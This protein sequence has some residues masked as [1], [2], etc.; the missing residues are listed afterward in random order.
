MKTKKFQ[1]ITQGT[2]WKQLLR[3]FI[4]VLFGSLFQMLYN[5]ADAIVVGRFVGTEALAAVGGTTGTLIDLVTGLFIGVASGASV[6]ISQYFGSKNIDDA[7]DAVHTAVAFS[8]S[9]GIV[10][11]IVGIWIAPLALRLLNTPESVMPLS[12]SYMRIYFSGVCF[13][14]FYNIGSSIQRSAGDSRR[15]MAVLIFCCILNISLD[16]LFVA[17]LSF[18]V[19]GAAWATVISQ[20]I[21]SVIVFIM[22]SQNP[23][24]CKV[25]I[26]KIK[27]HTIMLKEIIR[28]GLPVG[29][30]NS[31]YS[32]T[33]VFVQS[34]INIFGAETMA[35]WSAV[36]R[37][38]AMFWM[39]CGAIGVTVTTFS[40][41]NYG[42]GRIDRIRNSV[43]ISSLAGFICAGVF[44]SVLLLEGEPVLLM[45]STDSNVIEIGLLMFRCMGPFYGAYI[46]AETISAAMHGTGNTFI[47]MCISIASV[48]L[49][50]IGWVLYSLEVWGTLRSMLF[51]YPITWTLPTILYVCYY[52]RGNWMGKKSLKLIN[53][54]KA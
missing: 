39:V 13:S 30:N 10:L 1:D 2:I 18:G 27:F 25:E 44:T 9:V 36:R 21:S 17:V 46:L 50:R 4:P 40:G 23:Y 29:I 31:L 45:F 14:L 33:N 7:E 20:G 3:Y 32:I 28:I 24:G 34:R 8:L 5:T 47:P 12:V 43:R 54:L 53:K 26:R 52:L 37:V 6:I 15:P 16:L 35:A 38:D 11:T 48:L 19:S 49:V 51:G 42:A 22:L 41:Q